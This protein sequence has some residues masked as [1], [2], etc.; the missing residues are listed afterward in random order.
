MIFK[1]ELYGRKQKMQEQDLEL[2]LENIK[3]IDF[4]CHVM[5]LINVSYS[6]AATNCS[7]CEGS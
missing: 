2:I 3:N 7:Q 4:S 6:I 5:V 1:S